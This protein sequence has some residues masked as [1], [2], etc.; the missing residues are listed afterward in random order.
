M[1][2]GCTKRIKSNSQ[3]GQ[4]GTLNIQQKKKRRKGEKCASSVSF[5][6][7]IIWTAES[8]F[9]LCCSLDGTRD[10]R[11]EGGCSNF[12]FFWC[13]SQFVHSVL[14]GCM[15]CFVVA[16]WQCEKGVKEQLEVKGDTEG[17]VWR[18]RL[19]LKK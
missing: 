4:F 11:R 12:F 2:H 8:L 15:S 14:F 16:V 19:G 1:V 18:T 6:C 13:S 9:F 5:F 17:D 3:V 7:F 10:E